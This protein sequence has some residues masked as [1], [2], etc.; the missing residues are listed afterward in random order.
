MPSGTASPA[1]WPVDIPL[2]VAAALERPGTALVVF[3]CDLNIQYAAGSPEPP[4]GLDPERFG[5]GA[6]LLDQLEKRTSLD[7]SSKARMK[8]A[9]RNAVD[10]AESRS[11]G[12]TDLST[13]DGACTIV[14][15]T[16]RISQGCWVSTFED[17]TR[18]RDTELQLLNLGLHDPP[19]GL[20]DRSHFGRRLSAAVEAKSS[21]PAVLTLDLDR[22]KSV[23]DT[24]GHAAGDNLLRPI[25]Q[26]L[27]SVVHGSDVVA[28]M[29]GDEFAV[30]AYGSAGGCTA[31]HFPEWS[32]AFALPDA[33]FLPGFGIPA[34][35]SAKSSPSLAAARV[36]KLLHDVVVQEDWTMA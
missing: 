8:L 29:G 9:L 22:F 31:T 18:Q 23:N 3:G 20:D 1:V 13:V 6:R 30:L 33:R 16:R 14:L 21:M 10:G 11:S 17:T 27:K 5:F 24:L 15:Q 35:E 19:T 32:M 25:G 4:P 34:I 12:S 36:L 26:R 2:V 7:D 28:R